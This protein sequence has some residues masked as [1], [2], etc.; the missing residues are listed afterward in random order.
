KVYQYIHFEP[1]AFTPDQIRITNRYDFK[2]LS[3]FVLR[4][5]VEADG[6]EYAGGSMEM[7][8]IKPGESQ[9]VAMPLNLPR[10]DSR[11]FFLRLEAVYKNPTPFAE[12]D[13][14][15]AIA[16]WE[17][18]VSKKTAAVSPAGTNS[19]QVSE[20]PAETSITGTDFVISFSKNN[21][22]ITSLQYNKAEMIERGLIPN[23]WRPLTDND[24][25]N[26]TSERCGIWKK[27][28]PTL[29]GFNINKENE[30]QITVQTTYQLASGA[31]YAEYLYTILPDGIIKVDFSYR[32]DGK[33]LP[34]MPR[35]GMNMI[36]PA[37]YQQMNWFGRGPHENYAD[38]KT[39]ALVGRYEH[40]V[41]EQY[42]P[43]V[44]A[45]ET[46]NKCDVRWFTLSDKNGKGIL[47][48]GSQPLSVS[49]WNF[50]QETIDYVPFA[51]ERRHG[52]SIR[53][54]DFVWVNIDLLQM[55][56]G[57]DNTWGAQVHPEYTITPLD[58]SY[59]FTIEPLANIK[60]LDNQ[61]EKKWF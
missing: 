1:E 14:I 31:G 33:T 24:V 61:L 36:I 5:V 40:T 42:H 38:R 7:P 23:F 8:Q 12:K 43:Y 47:I 49:A 52:G 27:T 34:E 58:R 25:A 2:D 21:G 53:P 35:F 29:T 4:W 46:G 57:G 30:R 11:E 39:S 44:R 15:M 45:Q 54:K 50:D 9:A 60:Q 51:I 6:T 17:L 22:Q 59:S 19:L 37:D 18:P 20:S 55:G 10:E 26:G 28:S 32:N 41:T 48:R 56:V 3:D 16:Q 13:D